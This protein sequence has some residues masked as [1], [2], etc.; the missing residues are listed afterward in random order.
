[1]PSEGCTAGNKINEAECMVVAP[2]TKPK[3][4]R[5]IIVGEQPEELSHAH[6]E[7]FWC[8]AYLIKPSVSSENHYTYG[9]GFIN[10]FHNQN[11]GSE[12]RIREYSE[13]L[14]RQMSQYWEAESGGWDSLVVLCFCSSPHLLLL[15]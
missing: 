10:V 11:G 3:K 9:D 6:T 14:I 4:Q 7:S 12:R 13:A 1:M 15:E 5:V 2:W 8:R